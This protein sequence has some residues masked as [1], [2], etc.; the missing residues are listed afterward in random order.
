MSTDAIKLLQGRYCN[1]LT[2]YSRFV[3]REVYIGDVPMGGNN[4][5]R[6]QSM[7]T[8][9]T[10]DTIGTVEQSI[11]MIEAGCE[12]VRITAPSIKEAQNLAEIKKQLRQRGYTAPLVA[13]IHFTPNAA[14]V[15]ARIVEKVRVNPGNYADKKKFDQ[16]DYTDLEYQAELER[17]NKKF[18]PLVKICKEYGTAMRIGTNHGSLSDRIMSRYGDTPQGMV[19]SAMEFMRMCEALNYYNLVISMK[20][21]NPQVMVQAYRLLV[22]TMVAEGMNY[23]LH[24]GVTEA[25]DGEDGRIKSAVGIGTLLEDG[26]G[27]TVRV[28]L[29]EEPEAEA[30]VAIALVN[31]YVK[32]S[33]EVRAKSEE[34]S[35]LHTQIPAPTTHN[36]YEY[37]KRETYEANAFIGGH[38]VPRVVIDL[39]KANLKDPSVLNDAGYMYS[40][41]LDKYNMAEQSVDF[42][43]LADELPS[44]TLPGNLKQLYNYNTWQKLANKTLCHPVFTLQEYIGDVDRSSAL[45]LVRLKPADI[46]TEEFGLL[47]LNNTLVFI[48]ETDALN[49]MSDQRSFFFKMEKL[50]LDIPVVIKRNYS[51]NNEEA[52]KVSPAGG[53]LER[54]TTLLQLYAATDL[55]ALLV[56]GFGD[57]IWIDAPQL[58]ANIITSTAFG[59]L[60]ATRSRISKTEYISCPSCG[61]TL[62]DLM[63]TTQMIR[64]RTSHLKGLKIGIMGCI[65]NGPGEMADADYGYV[66]SGPGKVTLYRGKEAVKKNITSDNALDELIGIIREDGNWIEVE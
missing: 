21:S 66:G 57:G 10:M 42:V 19:E 32:R 56:D 17:I 36:P 31:R 23:P 13:D 59:I 7:T 25:G 33:E 37:K 53:D 18:A 44:F 47:P 55:G 52:K 54:A 12:Y 41:L 11:R 30:P 35:A 5:I 39:S 64:S 3:T 15:A 48:L 20:S 58:P 43:Y 38:M 9:D 45:N 65:V 28:S 34:I 50:G 22:E 8:T 2:E 62:F 1:S 6:I 51:F 29:T 14:E 16:I 24:L 49:G 26:L 61:R 40:P 27:D 60:Q 46:N 4:P 63:E